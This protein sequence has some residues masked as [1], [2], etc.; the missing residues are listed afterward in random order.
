MPSFCHREV[1]TKK[2]TKVAK[3]NPKVS[4]FAANF[5]VYIFGQI[6]YLLVN[7]RLKVRAGVTRA[8]VPWTQKCPSEHLIT[9]S[10][11]WERERAVQRRDLDRAEVPLLGWGGDHPCSAHC[12]VRGGCGD[13]VCR[14]GTSIIIGIN[15]LMMWGVTSSRPKTYSRCSGNIIMVNTRWLI[16]I[17]TNSLI[18]HNAGLT[19]SPS[20]LCNSLQYHVRGT[21]QANIW[22]DKLADKE[23]GEQ[24]TDH[25]SQGEKQTKFLK[26]HFIF[27]IC[28]RTRTST[29][30]KTM[31]LGHCKR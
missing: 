24:W 30:Y 6:Q 15:S 1:K 14:D 26:K 8:G 17:N 28:F 23:G 20:L 27:N 22:R 5:L 3:I 16:I 13:Q 11:G 31:K 18:T 9:L 10:G 25:P 12:R 21:A 29:E 4:Q 7:Q 2:D 19:L